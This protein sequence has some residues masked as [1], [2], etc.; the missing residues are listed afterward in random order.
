M[1]AD[2][3]AED[4]VY[5][6]VVAPYMRALQAIQVELRRKGKELAD[7]SLPLP[8]VPLEAAS[9][10]LMRE[11]RDPFPQDTQARLAV[12]L[13]MTLN[14]T[15]GLVFDAVIAALDGGHA[16]SGPRIFYVDGP[17]GS[18]KT[19]LYTAL[20]A[21]ARGR[22]YIALPCAPAG[23][24]ATLLPGGRTLHTR[25]G[26][27]AAHES[28]FAIRAAG[29]FSAVLLI[30]RGRLI[31]AIRIDRATTRAVT[32][33]G[34]PVNRVRCTTRGGLMVV[35]FPEQPVPVPVPLHN[36]ASSITSQE[37]RA[38]LLR[39]ATL[40]VVDEA[41]NA[42]KEV[43]NAMDTCL[44]DLMAHDPIQRT[45]PFGGKIVVLG[46][47]FRQ[48]PPVLR[49][50]TRALTLSQSLRRS[51]IW[52]DV[53]PYRLTRNMRARCACPSQTACIHARL[54]EFL[55]S[56]GDGTWPSQPYGDISVVELPR[57]IVF[58]HGT[59]EDDMLHDIFPGFASHARAAA[60][61]STPD[62]NDPLMEY[63]SLLGR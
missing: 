12:D 3:F 7:F 5:Q 22:G 38:D 25:F 28:N 9:S 53:T 40:I 1:F 23:L 48:I 45:M 56:V 63:R 35:A 14:D 15:Q 47:D 59:S 24:A 4:F 42:S 6:G 21:A 61:P 10:R 52:P 29:R 18:G 51:T 55:L 17:G 37:A 34:L 11:A 31:P 19:H 49:R 58:P 27:L 44:R 13:Q 8:N 62:G 36:A 60:R 20:L 57:E 39:A 2:D 54:R 41:P 16:Y 26:L 33:P 32:C 46:G 50:A 30:L 43:F